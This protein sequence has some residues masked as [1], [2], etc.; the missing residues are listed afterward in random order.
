[1]SLFEIISEIIRLVEDA[2][3]II[4]EGFKIF[5]KVRDFE[6]D[7]QIQGNFENGSF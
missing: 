4:A 5:V 2:A 6:I 3:K 7:S 1:M